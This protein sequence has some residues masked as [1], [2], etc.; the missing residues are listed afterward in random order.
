MIKNQFDKKI[1]WDYINSSIEEIPE[2]IRAQRYV[3]F[4]P[5]IHNAYIR[6]ELNIEE[7]KS[8]VNVIYQY[9]HPKYSESVREYV[10][11]NLIQRWFK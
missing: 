9:G 6:N 7:V 4:W 3:D 5:E 2:H 10:I 1:F 11:K 8:K